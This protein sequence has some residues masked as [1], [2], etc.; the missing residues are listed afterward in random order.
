MKRKLRKGTRRKTLDVKACK[1]ARK[2][3]KSIRE[4]GC[5]GASPKKMREKTQTRNK[6]KTVFKI[7][8]RVSSAIIANSTIDNLLFALFRLP[9]QNKAKQRQNQK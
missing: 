1:K 7:G 2:A 3:S 4:H 9:E 6:F 5:I 8:I